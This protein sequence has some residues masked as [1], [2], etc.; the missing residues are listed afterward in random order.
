VSAVGND[1]LKSQVFGD[2]SPAPSILNFV[3]GS[4]QTEI[5]MDSNVSQ[6]GQ[7]ASKTLSNTAD[8]SSVSLASHSGKVPEV[9]EVDKDDA[10]DAVEKDVRCSEH[11]SEINEDKAVE[12]DVPDKDVLTTHNDNTDIAAP[13]SPEVDHGKEKG[14]LSCISQEI[15][16]SHSGD[17]SDA[18]QSEENSETEELLL[19][20]LHETVL[21]F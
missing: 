18:G 13:P 14:A 11:A 5:D 2:T 1:V 7:D 16:L 10:L 6:G 19:E 21:Y 3:T 17:Q 8:D 12:K 4:F 9:P 15:V 20:V